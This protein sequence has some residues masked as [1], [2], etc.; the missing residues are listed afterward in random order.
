MS[1]FDPDAVIVRLAASQHGVVSRGQL[2]AA[3]LSRHMI[4]H[5][6]RRGRLVRVHRAVYAV[7]P[8]RGRHHREMAAVLAYDGTAVASHE[9]AAH[10]WELPVRRRGVVD[11]SVVGGRPGDRRG[12]RVHRLGALP[13]EEI[14]VL[15]ALP[16]TTPTRTLLDLAGRATGRRLERALATALDRGLTSGAA[17]ERLLARHRGRPGCPALRVLLHAER[18]PR[19]TRSEAEERFLTTVRDGQLPEP[20]ANQ[21]ICGLEV[22]FLWRDRRLVVE[23]DGFA[24]HSSRQAFERDRDRDAILLAAG[25]RVMR[26]T[27]RK[28]VDQP[29]ATLARLAA[30]LGPPD[31]R[32][33]PSRSTVPT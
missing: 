14:T 15:D 11:V 3:G 25:Y 24:F 10:L 31:T 32:N 20:E 5:R 6:L 8:I 29:G 21:R 12:I 13:P 1:D 23:I 7:G 19:L 33:L 28:L 22:D 9:T 18:Q 2:L 30:A 27:W 17:M 16:I 26:L 4:D